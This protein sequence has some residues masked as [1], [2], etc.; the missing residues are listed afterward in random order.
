MQVQK[1]WQPLEEVLGAA[2][3][4]VE[5]QLRDH[6]VTTDLPSD[7]PLV[8]LD[9]VLMGYLAAILCRL[10]RTLMDADSLSMR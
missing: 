9:S 1:E 7:L 3:T 2:V 4:R 10:R 5:G 6:I 8:P